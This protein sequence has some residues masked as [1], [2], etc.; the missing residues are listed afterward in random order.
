M[1]KYNNPCFISSHNYAIYECE[2]YFKN[3]LNIRDFMVRIP[4][5]KNINGRLCLRNF[6]CMHYIT[7]NGKTLVCVF[8][9]N[10][11][12]RKFYKYN[13]DTHDIDIYHMNAPE[14]YVCKDNMYLSGSIPFIS[15]CDNNTDVFLVKNY[16]GLSNIYL[17][18]RALK[19]LFNLNYRIRCILWKA[20]LRIARLYYNARFFRLI[21]IVKRHK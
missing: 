13:H 4:L 21:N 15:S 5:V 17:K 3:H 16:N 11:A 2:K 14:Q 12:F 18:C 6:G 10:K 8:R 9:G 7:I 20:R 1:K 19:R